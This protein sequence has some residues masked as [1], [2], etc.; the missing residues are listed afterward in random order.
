MRKNFWWA[1]T[2]EMLSAIMIDRKTK[3]LISNRLKWLENLI[4]IGGR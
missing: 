4:F 2:Y 3:F 1:T